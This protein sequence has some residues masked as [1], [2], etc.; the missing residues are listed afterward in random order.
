MY[1]GFTDIPPFDDMIKPYYQIDSNG[2]VINKH[3]GKQIVPHIN[4]NGYWQVSLMTET[5]RVFRKVHRLVLLVFDFNP[6]YKYLQGNHKDGD[7]SHNYLSNLEWATPKE[8]KQHSIITGLSDGI[9]GSHNPT[10]IISEEEAIQIADLIMEGMKTNEILKYFPYANESIIYNLAVGNTWS[11]LFHPDF[12]DEMKAMYLDTLSIR[13]KHL[14]CQFYQ[15]HKFDEVR[16]GSVSNKVRGALEYIG[17]PYTDRYFKI[18][19]RLYYRY[20]NPEIT[21]LYDY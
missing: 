11:F 9:A 17:Y 10:A 19:K 16:Y 8:N 3:T 12:I 1:I 13:N 14:I 6:N 2:V 21:S 4:H 20:D 15:A 7:K 18:A 5:G